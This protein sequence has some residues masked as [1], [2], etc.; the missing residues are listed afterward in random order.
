MD[1]EYNYK[2]DIWRPDLEH[3]LTFSLDYAPNGM[4]IDKS[5]LITWNPAPDQI[6]N[7]SFKVRVN[8]GIAVD[9]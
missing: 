3:I 2:V 1:K 6:D 9:T 5:G 4:K 8:H 7:Q